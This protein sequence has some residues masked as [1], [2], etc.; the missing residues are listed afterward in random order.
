M[1]NLRVVNFLDLDNRLQR[2][3]RLAELVDINHDFVWCEL[4]K[5]FNA[6]IDHLVDVDKQQRGKESLPL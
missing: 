5:S 1:K 4:I 6:D 3:A 2:K